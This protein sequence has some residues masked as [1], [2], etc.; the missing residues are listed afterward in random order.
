[1]MS[2]SSNS[3]ELLPF[4]RLIAE[5]VAMVMVG[6]LSVPALDPSGTPAS[7]SRPIMTDVLKGELGFKGLVVTDALEMRGLLNG[8]D[9]CAVVLEAFKAGADLLLMPKDAQGAIDL[10]TAA[11]ENG[12]VSVA[13][14]DAKVRKM[15]LVKARL[16]LLNARYDPS[17]RDVASKV[18]KACR[19]DERL[20]GRISRRM[21]E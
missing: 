7:I 9:S 14:L 1:M 6:H 21:T 10:V 16:G 5:D 8:R 3:V 2:S 18:K 13:E 12:E 4:R 11:V 20:I 17:V 15:L 19:R